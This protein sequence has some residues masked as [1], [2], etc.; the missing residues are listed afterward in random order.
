[1]RGLKYFGLCGIVEL[2]RT[3]DLDRERS[4]K[5][6]SLADFLSLYN[7]NLPDTFPKASTLLLEEFKG[8]HAGLFPRRGNVWSL[9]QHRRKVMDWLRSQAQTID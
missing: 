4:E 5:K 1:M 9:D 8:A 7:E 6:R 2:M 3:P